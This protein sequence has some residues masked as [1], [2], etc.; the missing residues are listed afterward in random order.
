MIKKTL[1]LLSV[2]SLNVKVYTSTPVGQGAPFPPCSPNQKKLYAEA[3]RNRPARPA[4]VAVPVV[5][6]KFDNKRS[7]NHVE[8]GHAKRSCLN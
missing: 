5:Q 8:T 2:F 1:V 4:V 3:K 7:G 6:L